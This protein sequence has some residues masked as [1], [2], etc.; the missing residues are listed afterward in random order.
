MRTQYTPKLI[1][2]VEQFSKSMDYNLTSTYIVHND[3]SDRGIP[4]TVTRGVYEGTREQGFV[5]KDTP[6][7]RALVKHYMKLH[8]QE[9]FLELSNEGFGILH[10]ENASETIGMLKTYTK[11]PEGNHTFIPSENT[12]FN[13]V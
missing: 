8:N 11:A 1:F 3:L 2:S 5:V 7:N 4:F 10:Y 13:F 6:E 12:Y 9:C